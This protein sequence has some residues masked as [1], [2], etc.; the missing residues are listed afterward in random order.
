[1]QKSE[2]MTIVDGG[3]GGGW[4]Y[5]LFDGHTVTK[6]GKSSKNNKPTPFALRRLSRETPISALSSGEA[7]DDRLTD[8][9]KRRWLGQHIVTNL[10]ERVF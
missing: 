2:T 10:L 1:M 7:H 6:G 8:N 5:F 4:L 9:W 3:G